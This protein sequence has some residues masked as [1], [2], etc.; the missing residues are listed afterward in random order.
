[1]FPSWS[2]RLA[3]DIIVTLR[4][5]IVNMSAMQYCYV[6]C[7]HVTTLAI[8]L[9]LLIELIFIRGERRTNDEEVI[10]DRRRG[11]ESSDGSKIGLTRK[12]CVYSLV[13]IA[14][15]KKTFAMVFMRVS[16]LENRTNYVYV[17]KATAFKIIRVAL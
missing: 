10:G 1:M 12:R 16:C 4:D 13:A 6:N 5:K 9:Y 14:I 2:V 11:K 8:Y 3:A 17:R 7:G 15:V